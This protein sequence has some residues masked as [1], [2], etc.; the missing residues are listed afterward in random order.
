MLQCVWIHLAHNQDLYEEDN[1][2]SGSI[3]GGY[4][5]GQLMGY[6]L[7]KLSSALGVYR[8]QNTFNTDT[9][10][11]TKTIM[12]FGI[13]FHCMHF[14]HSILIVKR[15]CNK[16]TFCLTSP[17]QASYHAS[18]NTAEVNMR[19]LGLYFI[20]ADDTLSIRCHELV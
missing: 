10:Y 19:S 3:N 16:Q 8:R 13:C 12:C 2:H 6:L 14:M 20:I 4:F 11:L 17:Y 18:F 9:K 1:E 7:H 5:L 15:L